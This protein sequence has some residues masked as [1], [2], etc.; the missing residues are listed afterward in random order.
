[1]IRGV[2]VVCDGGGAVMVGCDLHWPAKFHLQCY[3]LLTLGVLT[4]QDMH[5]MSELLACLPVPGWPGIF[6]SCK[7]C[8]DKL[9]LVD[10]YQ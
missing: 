1:M 2:L 5:S 4:P 7:L 6:S 10:N 3:Q 8:G 9:H